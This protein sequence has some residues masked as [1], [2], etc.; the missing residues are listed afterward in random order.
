[1]AQPKGKSNV[2]RQ[3]S[4]LN[5]EYTMEKAIEG[6]LAEE[7]NKRVAENDKTNE[8]YNTLVSEKV[9]D[10]DCEEEEDDDFKCDDEILRKMAE[11]RMGDMYSDDTLR[12]K[13]QKGQI[14]EFREVDEEEFFKIVTN[15]KFVVCSFM[16]TDFNRCRIAEMHLQK[17]AYD[18]PEC[19]FIQIDVQKCPFLVQKLLVVVLPTVAMFKD[20]IKVDEMN[21]FDDL[22]GR[23]EFETFA[24]TRRIARAKVIELKEEEKFKIERVGKE[25][26][27]GDS[28]SDSEET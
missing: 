20:G 4:A 19:K 10:P 6:K 15:N 2:M 9:Y 17:I 22:G 27:A 1:M 21:G 5:Q 12:K 28:D 26:V 3:F 24:L 23:D 16:H 14:G 18:H 13:Q 7:H 25:K 8:I 11:R